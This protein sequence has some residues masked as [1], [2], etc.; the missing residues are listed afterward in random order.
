MSK[1]NFLGALTTESSNEITSLIDLVSPEEGMRLISKVESQIFSSFDEKTI[2]NLEKLTVSIF[3]AIENEGAIVISGAGTS[4]RMAVH[5]SNE[6]NK[7]IG[8]E[9]FKP[10]ISGGYFTLVKSKE[11]AEDMPKVGLREVNKLWKD[12]EHDLYIAITCSGNAK[13]CMYPVNYIN[14]GK[15]ATIMFNEIEQLKNHVNYKPLKKIEEEGILINPIIGPEAI[16]GSTRMKGGTATQMI[17]DMIIYSALNKKGGSDF[18]TMLNEYDLAHGVVENK[19]PELANIAVSLKN[20]FLNNGNIYYISEGELGKTAITDASECM[21]TFGVEFEKVRGYSGDG[22]VEFIESAQLEQI[23]SKVI[24]KHNLSLEA[25]MKL[26]LSEKDTVIMIHKNK[27][28][29]LMKAYAYAK[30]NKS[31]TYELCINSNKAHKSI[32]CINLDFKSA[33]FPD[34]L[35]FDRALGKWALNL[36]TTEAFVLSGKTWKNTMIDLRLTNTK[37]INRAV[38]RVIYPIMKNAYGKEFSTDKIIDEINK[39]ASLYLN[40]NFRKA[41]SKQYMKVP[42]LVPLTLLTLGGEEYYNARELLDN[43]EK[44]SMILQTHLGK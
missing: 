41:S 14:G 12:N 32:D 38:N 1:S 42:K 15:I 35:G 28:A 8:K 37:L 9:V 25:F 23:D 4:G 13:Y 33:N 3:R 22:W 2:S 40:R 27:S 43:N 19:I 5:L 6:Y 29:K 21:P 44:V 18:G 10:L 16:T 31:Q 20:S 36:I 39:N 11:L 24:N 17:L 30:E 7:R 26:K 34:Y